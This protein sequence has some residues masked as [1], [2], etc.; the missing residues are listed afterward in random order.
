MTLRRAGP[1]GSAAALLFLLAVAA[2]SGVAA[3]E[4]PP[5]PAY[6]IAPATGSITVDGVL[7]EP[8]WSL[9]EEI[10]LSWE[11]LPGDN[12]PPPVETTCRMVFDTTMLYFSCRAFDPEP[13][14]IRAHLAD[15]DDRVRTIQDDHIVFLLDPFND[16][17][18]GF[19]FRVNAIGV[20][21]DAVLARSEG[22]EDFAWNAVWYSEVRRTEEGY[23]VEVGIPFGS[24]RF[25][26]TDGPQTWGLVIDRSYPRS[27][28]YR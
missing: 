15:R 5:A 16:E 27:V 14:R 11:V 26:Q 9:A 10:P 4:L 28:R 6:T 3:Q 18:R 20:Q 17:R 8:D 22:I 7:D 24:L 23:D 1:P 13:E 25:P 21:M 2:G 19:E 12:V